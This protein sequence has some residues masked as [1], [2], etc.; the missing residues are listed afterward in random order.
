MSIAA[1]SERRVANAKLLRAALWGLIVA[2][3]DVGMA[4][5]QTKLEPA[6]TK[7]T[8]SE[9]FEKSRKARLN[10]SGAACATKVPPFASCVIVNDE[11]KYAQFFSM[12]ETV[13]H[14]GK[15]IRLTADG[16]KGDPDAEG[17]AYDGG[18]F[19]ITGSHGRSRHHPKEKNKSS[20]VI[21]RFR[22]DT[23]T[24]KPTFRVSDEKVIGVESSHRIRA[25]I[26]AEVRKFY[27]KQLSKNGA[28]I[29]GIAVRDGRIY[30]G[31]RGP[32]DDG[33]AFV[34]SVD[35]RAAFTPDKDL[36]AVSNKLQLGP[37]TGI[38]DL[39]A[40]A[41]GMLVLTGPVNEQ[42]VTPA[43]RH[44]DPKTGVLGPAREL[45]IPDKAKKGK[46]ETLL[47]LKDVEG[48]PWRALVM[49][50]GVKNGAPT[51]YAI[52]R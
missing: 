48:E 23:A 19:Y 4:A 35:A 32:S 11:K 49:F 18:Y 2:F 15:V 13:I 7:W 45:Q 25:V 22:V 9:N 20:Y 3:A 41:D 52:P 30:F 37:Y 12:D 44:W 24:G 31:L 34:I 6:A 46:A 29:E 26:K 1:F 50:D 43:L 28:N 5:A 42:L 39:A 8:V 17:A 38:R 36:Q 14:P 27:D 21:F 10:L 33:E 51:E 47:I 40:V 16:K